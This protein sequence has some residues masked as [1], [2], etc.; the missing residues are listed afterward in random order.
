M[1][2]IG[3]VACGLSLTILAKRARNDPMDDLARKQVLTIT[4]GVLE[5]LIAIITACLPTM[6]ALWTE[7]STNSMS[8]LRRLIL[9]VGLRTTLSSRS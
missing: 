1:L 9:R 7:L 6:P 5:L 2:C 8:L 4:L 3:L